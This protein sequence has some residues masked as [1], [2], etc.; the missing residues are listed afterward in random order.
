MAWQDFVPSWL[1]RAA[2]PAQPLYHA[3]QLWSD[4]GGMRMSAAMSFY[5]ILSLAPL[6][7]VMV[8]L[9]G[10]WMDRQMLADTLVAQ[11]GALVGPQGAAVVEQALSSAQQPSEGIV[12]TAIGFGVLLFGATGVFGELQEA[13]ARVWAD[14]GSPARPG[15]RHTASLRLRGVAYIL[16]FGFLLVVSLVVS[17]L[18]TVFSARLGQVFMLETVL[19]VVN[20]AVSF[21]LCTA[22]FVSL[23]RLSAGPKPQLRFLVLGGVMGAILFSVGRQLLSLYL[24]TAA[25]VSAYGAAGSLVVLLMWI[26]FSSAVLL[27]AAS[28]AKAS[29][30]TWKRNSGIYDAAAAPL[31][32]NGYPHLRAVSGTRV[33]A[34]RPGAGRRDARYR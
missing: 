29:Q 23:M 28:C 26:Y 18:I 5:G 4:A 16:A 17:T 13:F 1:R 15:W 19:R 32:P 2:R 27:F 30:E 34:A 20:E 25:V 6:L 33:S 8:A 24:A 12:A 21:G 3:V 22:L 9:L 31:R 11:I 10:W 14:G 7:L